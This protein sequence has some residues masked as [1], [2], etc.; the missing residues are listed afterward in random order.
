M[1]MLKSLQIC[2]QAEPQTTCWRGRGRKCVAPDML[3]GL[4]QKRRTALK[5]Q[6]C[7]SQRHLA[8]RLQIGPKWIPLAHLQP[9]WLLEIQWQKKSPPEPVFGLSILGYCRNMAV[10][11]ILHSGPF[12]GIVR[13]YRKYADFLFSLKIRWEHWYRSRI[14]WLSMRL[15]PAAG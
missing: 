9:C 2:P 4:L 13:H 5:G 7:R 14:R 3:R 11:D 6:V 15:Q 1:L 12:N 10:Q 8:V